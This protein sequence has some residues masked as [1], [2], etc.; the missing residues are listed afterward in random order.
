MTDFGKVAVLYGGV[1]AERD[2]S[3]MSGENV[4]QALQA[5]A[6]D[7]FPVLIN[8][9]PI[10]QL[11]SLKMDRVFN[12]LHGKH[13][14]DGHLQGAL[15]LLNIPYFGSGV[16]A[17]ALSFD[18]I[19]CKRF[20]QGC[21]LSTPPM[22]I[23][24]PQTTVE[25]CESKLGLP[26]VIKPSTE[27][28]SVG[29]NIVKSKHDFAAAMEDVF[30]YGAE[31]LA[32]K[33]IEGDEYALSILNNEPLPSIRIEVHDAEFY[34]YHAKYF[35]D[36]TEYHLPSGLSTTQENQLAELS[37]QA[38]HACQCQ[39]WG[40]VDVIHEKATDTFWLIE[41]NTIPGMTTHSLLPKAAKAAGI[42]FSELLLKLLANAK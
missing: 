17:S 38:F 8:D 16:L 33:F 20:W 27:G 30:Q 7:A 4:L 18:K 39:D 5:A 23:C 9:D 35:S 25:D 12:I 10:R 3:I 21:G 24:H 1:G 36:K 6:V 14:E 13:Y 40:R 37:L 26:F 19:A 11:S 15:E 42:G 2:I 31:V 29:V 22:M 34:N 41:L 28:S 32:E